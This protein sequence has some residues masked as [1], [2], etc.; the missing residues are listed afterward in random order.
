MA[1]LDAAVSGLSLLIINWGWG[2]LCHP[3]RSMGPQYGLDS[4][5]WSC[6]SVN[7]GQ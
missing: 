6:C 3:D 7:L 5:F 2:S 4:I 1:G